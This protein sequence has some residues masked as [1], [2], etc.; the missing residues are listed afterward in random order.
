MPGG[1]RHAYALSAAGGVLAAAVLCDC[2]VRLVDEAGERIVGVP[3][4]LHY[5]Q[6]LDRLQVTG[7]N[8]AL[9]LR[10]TFLGRS[11]ADL[12]SL[13]GMA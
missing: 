10:T 9:D 5:F 7:V 13:L 12:P 3:P 11:G 2:H 1:V 6:S 4:R 8:L